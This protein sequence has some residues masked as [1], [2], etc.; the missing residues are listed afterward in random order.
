MLHTHSTR[1]LILPLLLAAPTWAD[2]V[3][4]TLPASDGFV[5]QNNTASIE[6]LR[7]DESTGNISRNGALFV[8]TTG[9]R[10][11]FVGVSAGN[12]ST[13]DYGRNSAFGANA[14]YAV[15]DGAANSAFGFSALLS[16]TLGTSNSAFGFKAMSFNTTG[17][18]NAAFGAS[19]L[20]RNMT[21]SYNSAFGV[22][23]LTFNTTGYSNAALGNLALS[24]NTAGFS[25]AALGASA[26]HENIVG[27]FNTAVGYRTLYDNIS[28][29]QNVA[30]GNRALESNDS[31]SGNIAIGSNAGGNQTSG[32][33]NIY[34]G[35]EGVAAENGQIRIGNT[36]DHVQATI[37]GI[38]G[39]TV[40]TGIAVLVDSTGLL[41]TTTSSA[42]FKEAGDRSMPSIGLSKP[43]ARN[44]TPV[45]PVPQPASRSTEPAGT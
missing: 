12:T 42:R 26:L 40:P 22:A 6:R 21:G 8:H 44:A 10:N 36:T 9:S 7:V 31:G 23:A 20:S 33:S 43:A 16:T 39:N 17:S 45:K 29:T 19:A 34:I 32:D 28:G 30:V 18:L 13:S 3:T 1:L 15:T 2:D 11:T 14:L 25:N 35:N 5:V 4:V 27:N 37:A 24:R 41:G 38:H